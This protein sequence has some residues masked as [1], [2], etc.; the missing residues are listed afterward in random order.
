MAHLLTGDDKFRDLGGADGRR[1]DV[2]RHDLSGNYRFARPH[3]KRR[4]R[5][6]SALHRINGYLKTMIEAIADFEGTQD[7][8]P[9][10]TSRHSFRSARRKPS[11]VSLRAD[12]AFKM[13]SPVLVSL[14][15]A[16]RAVVTF[17]T[18]VG[19]AG[20]AILSRGALHARPRAEISGKTQSWARV[21]RLNAR[22]HVRPRTAVLI[23]QSLVALNDRYGTKAPSIGHYAV[24]RAG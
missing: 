14:L 2:T 10:R 23:T 19:W 24:G 21:V 11:G 18:V 6:R 5:M 13:K 7:A 12:R 20:Q 3:A 4:S 22:P 17:W 8:A 1:S 15:R 9:S 16:V